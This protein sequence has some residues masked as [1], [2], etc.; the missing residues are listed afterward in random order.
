MLSTLSLIFPEPFPLDSILM[1]SPARPHN[2]KRF[3]SLT[4]TYANPYNRDNCISLARK[5]T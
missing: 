2:R 1:S 4:R 5:Y 3:I